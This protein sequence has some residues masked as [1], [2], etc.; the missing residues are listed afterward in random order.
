MNT[1]TY[2]L[3]IIAIIVI[4]TVTWLVMAAGKPTSSVVHPEWSRNLSIYEVNLRQYTP[5]GT[6]K[7]FE[8]HLARLKD[9]DVG[10]LWFMPIYPIGEKN[11]KGSLGSYYSVKDYMAVNPEFGTMDDFKALVKQCHEQGMYVILDWVANH[12]AWDNVM[13]KDHPDW[14]TKDS[15]GNFVSPVPDWHD[16]MDINY[17][18]PELQAYMINALKFW[19]EQANIDGYRCDVSGMVPMEFWNKART[20]LE[21]I[22]PVFMLA[23]D[24]NPA[25]HEKAFDMTYGWE[26]VHL[27]NDFSAGKKTLDD[28]EQYFKKNAENYPADAYRMYFTSNH[29]ENSW[30]GTEFERLKDAAKPFAVLAFTAPGMPLVYSGQE[31]GLQKRLRFFDKDTIL[32]QASEYGDL[33]KTLIHLKKMNPA[34][35]NGNLGGDLIRVRTSEDKNCFAFIRTKA[36]KK[37]VVILNLSGPRSEDHVEQSSH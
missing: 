25:C 24:E 33:Y 13:V 16:V 35:W 5:S 18:N 37:V 8:P 22:K 31:T 1:R 23:E 7:D 34:L 32:W 4:L 29:D 21:K 20:E 36:E 30:N 27:M 11:R 26:L 2:L 6:I 15:L 10:I 14:F 28:L 3:P 17:D 9:M 12:A 19:I